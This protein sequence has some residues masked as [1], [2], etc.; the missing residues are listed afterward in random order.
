M[1]TTLPEPIADTFNCCSQKAGRATEGARRVCGNLRHQLVD[2][3]APGPVMML[4][5][6]AHKHVSLGITAD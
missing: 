1:F 3:G 6:I 2:P 4:D 5:R